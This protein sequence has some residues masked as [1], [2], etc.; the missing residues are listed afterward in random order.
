MNRRQALKSLAVVGSVSVAGCSS[1]LDSGGSGTVLGPIEVINSSFISN[2][3]RIMVERD[4]GTRSESD[5]ESLL[6]RKLSLPAI[7]AETGTPGL[8][9]APSWSETQAHYTIRAVHYDG[10]DDRETEVWEYTFTREDYKTYYA[11]RNEDPGCI[12]ALVKI[13]SLSTAGNGAI[14]IGP[15][16]MEDPCGTSGSQ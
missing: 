10:S 3:V 5:D 4:E 6:D 15:T 1:V 11:D 13:G 16:Y 14:G 8:R 9:I 12:G 2:R 7:D